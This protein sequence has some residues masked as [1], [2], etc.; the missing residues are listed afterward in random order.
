MPFP[1]PGLPEWWRLLVKNLKYLK[2]VTYKLLMD[3]QYPLEK[4]AEAHSNIES[5]H[6][7]GNVIIIVNTK[8]N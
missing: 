3:R 1:K 8:T 6:I 2:R 7:K 4:L 5:G